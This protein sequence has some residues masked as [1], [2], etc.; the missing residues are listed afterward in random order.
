[1]KDKG[2]ENNWNSVGVFING[3][4][5]KG[6]RS[7][8]YSKMVSLADLEVELYQAILHEEYE[9]CADLKKQID[10]LKTE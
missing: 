2:K 10:K 4:E 9:L 8:D 3:K 1:M 5:I 6:I 7:V